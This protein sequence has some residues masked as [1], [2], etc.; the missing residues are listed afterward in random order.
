MDLLAPLAQGG[1]LPRVAL[2]TLLQA[3]AVILVAALISATLLR[4]RAAAR[5]SLWL[6]TLVWVILSPAVVVVTG[7]VRVPIPLP[8]VILPG[9]PDRTVVVEL[10]Y[11]RQGLG[12]VADGVGGNV[13]PLRSSKDLWG[14]WPCEV[15]KT[16]GAHRLAMTQAHHEIEGRPLLRASAKLMPTRPNGGSV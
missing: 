11:G 4:R 6:F 12:R 14:P 8:V 7:R 9:T 3:T 15:H 1:L 16:W 2:G 5:Y 10:G 13:A